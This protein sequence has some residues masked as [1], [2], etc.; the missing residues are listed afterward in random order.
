LCGCNEATHS[1]AAP[2]G[3]VF[4]DK[5][6]FT[7]E[8]AHNRQN[9]RSWPVEA[10]G[11]SSVIE[12][13]QNQQA[14]IVWDG[15]YASGKTPLVI[16]NEGVKINK[17]YYQSK[18]LEAVVLPWAQQHFGKPGTDI[19]GGFCSAAQGENDSE[20][21]QSPFSGFH[22]ICGMATLLT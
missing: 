5:K 7:V 17:D 6:L 4:T 22:F 13:R 12:H 18:I 16:V 14:V 21:V 8:Q 1:S 20:V 11:P 3:I 19:P 9:D 2:Q 10:P 15:I